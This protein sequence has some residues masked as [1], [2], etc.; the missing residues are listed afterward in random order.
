[1]PVR[2][3]YAEAPILPAYAIVLL[4]LGAATVICLALVLALATAVWLDGSARRKF[5]VFAC[6]PTLALYAHQHYLIVEQEQREAAKGY[7]R[8]QQSNVR[9]PNACRGESPAEPRMGW[10]AIRASQTGP[11][12]G[13]MLYERP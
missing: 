9:Q 2:I 10:T 13:G 5:L 1:M 6:L 8:A 7:R 4:V 11:T 12:R 3:Y